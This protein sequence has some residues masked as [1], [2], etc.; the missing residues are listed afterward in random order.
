[1]VV[2]V[3]AVAAVLAATAVLL[4]NVGERASHGVDVSPEPRRIITTGFATLT[5]VPDEARVTVG[6]VTRGETAE[7]ASRKNAEVMTRVIE[8]LKGLGLTEREIQTRWL[9]VNAEYDCS[10][11]RCTVSGYVATNTVEVKLR[12]ERFQLIS[13]VIDRTVAAGA[14]LVQ[15]VHFSVSEEMRKSVEEELLRAAIADARRKA[16]RAMEELGSGIRGVLYV[17]LSIDQIPYP[18]V[19]AMARGESG[20]STP[21]VP[22]EVTVTARVQVSFEI[23]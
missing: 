16:Q 14:N 11:G 10:G 1:M 8:A 4:S 6:V 12:S 17:D 5:L 20:A 22:G 13:E 7:E 9:S 3:V 19:P 23:G 18:I 2:M 21:V 15:G